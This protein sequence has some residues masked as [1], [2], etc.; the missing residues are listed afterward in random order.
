MGYLHLQKSKKILV[1]YRGQRQGLG[2]SN[3]RKFKEETINLEKESYKNA[4]P[5]L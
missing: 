2:I 4:G 3:N 5:I 1:G